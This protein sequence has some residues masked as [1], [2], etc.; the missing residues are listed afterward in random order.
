M[1]LFGL[2][3]FFG[4]LTVTGFG[5]ARASTA[6]Q[7]LFVIFNAFQGFFIF[8]FLCVL[9]KDARESWLNLV[10]F[11]QCLSKSSQAMSSSSGAHAKVKTASTSLGNSRRTLTISGTSG[12]NLSTDDLTKKL[13]VRYINR[14]LTGAA[15]REKEKSPI[16]IFNEHAVSHEKS[17]GTDQNVDHE[18]D[19]VIERSNNS[20]EHASP[21]QWR[22]DEIELKA[23]VLHFST[24]DSCT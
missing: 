1:F 15:E 20:E 14:P 2:T 22:E 23:F 18:K 21:S 24:E 12:Y 5:D 7:V 19:Q 4:A 6:F 8:L 17:V 13:T 11:N 9:S 10:S 16:V 3:W